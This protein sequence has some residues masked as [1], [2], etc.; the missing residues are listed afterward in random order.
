M[1]NHW[2]RIPLFY[3]LFTAIYFPCAAWI[4]ASN[5]EE[6]SHFFLRFLD[7]LDDITY[8]GKVYVFFFITSILSSLIGLF[9]HRRKGNKSLAFGFLI[10]FLCSTLLFVLLM[11]MVAIT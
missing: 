2:I 9:W 8:W 3:L 11:I 10:V 5:N 1:K 7:Y 6:G 4:E